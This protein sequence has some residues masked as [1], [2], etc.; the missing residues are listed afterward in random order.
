MQIHS[1]VNEYCK[2]YI[3]PYVSNDTKGK[4]LANNAYAGLFEFACW[5]Y[6]KK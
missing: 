4:E 2:E 6:N 1:L 3:N 5:I